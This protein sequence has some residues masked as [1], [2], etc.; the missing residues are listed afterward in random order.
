MYIPAHF[1]VS[2]EATLL[3]FMRE[4]SFAILFTHEGGSSVAT[5]LPLLIDDDGKGKRCLIG[6]VAR[7]NPQ[8]QH[9]VGDALAVFHGPHAYV[10]PTWYGQPKNVPTW[11]YAAVHVY[12]RIEVCDHP[13]EK[14]A[15][16]EKM[17]A[18]YEGSQAKPWRI[19]DIPSDFRDKLLTALTAFRIVILRIEGKWKLNQNKSEAERA[20]VIRALKDSPREHERE[21]A[22]LMEWKPDA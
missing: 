15:I 2:D 7:A 20:G 9:L 16:L 13:S 10:S 12:G 14:L 1:K 21:I 19:A 4:N 22:R 8:T 3:N 18:F 6:H 17:T 11:N 5:H